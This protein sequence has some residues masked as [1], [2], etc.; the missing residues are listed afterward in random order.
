MAKLCFIKFARVMN[1]SPVY[2]LLNGQSPSRA[3]V[4]PTV[5]MS[6]LTCY[7]QNFAV[8]VHVRNMLVTEGSN[9]KLDLAPL[10]E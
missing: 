2:F 6:R 1:S 3:T 8:H 4:R 10:D 9:K 5:R 7:E